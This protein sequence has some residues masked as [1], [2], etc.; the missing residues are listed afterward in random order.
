MGDLKTN[1]SAIML[2]YCWSSPIDTWDNPSLCAA[3]SYDI[4]ATPVAATK[5]ELEIGDFGH[6]WRSRSS[7]SRLQ[8]ARICS[9]TSGRV[10][11]R[12]C[13]LTVRKKEVGS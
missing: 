1:G 7:R 2:P 6:M 4:S 3:D 8:S 10:Q 12:R 11:P 9:P 5:E 13:L